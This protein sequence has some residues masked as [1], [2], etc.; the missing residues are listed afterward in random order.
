VTGTYPAPRLNRLQRLN[1]DGCDIVRRHWA[2]QA[3]A[4]PLGADRLAELTAQ[5]LVAAMGLAPPV[6]AVDLEAGWMSMPFIAGVGLDPH[7]W[8]LESTT[9]S[10]LGVLG[11]LRTLPASQLPVISLADRARALHRRLADLQPVVAER[12]DSPLQRCFEEWGRESALAEESLQCFVHGDVSADNLLCTADGRLML[13]DFEYAHRGHRLEDLAGLVA[14]GAI[15][16][17]RWSN[18]V[19]TVEHV[20]FETLVRARTVLDGLWTD[21]AWTLT[22]NAAAARAH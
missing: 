16:V 5:R 9:K 22:G 19:P 3:I 21:L 4:D 10:V 8:H 14:S 1:E 13:L 17:D 20:L 18:W 6:L 15:T 2:A 11:V 12:W 7:W